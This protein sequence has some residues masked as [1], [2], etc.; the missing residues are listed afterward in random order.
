MTEI[1]KQLKVASFHSPNACV[2][3]SKNII[4]I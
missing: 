1:A 2:F 4:Y 3:N